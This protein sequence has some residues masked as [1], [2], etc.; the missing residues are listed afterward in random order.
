M[1]TATSLRWLEKKM[2]LLYTLE[3]SLLKDASSSG[4]IEKNAKKLGAANTSRF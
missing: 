2:K 3:G 1:T 4:Q